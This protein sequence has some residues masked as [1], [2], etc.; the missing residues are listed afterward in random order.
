MWTHALGERIK[1]KKENRKEGESE[2]LTHE[3][4]LT[5]ATS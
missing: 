5:P 3:P 2:N 1:A 4:I